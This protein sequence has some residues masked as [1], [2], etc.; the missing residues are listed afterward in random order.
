MYYTNQ[1]EKV[2]GSVQRVNN[3]EDI[4][5]A[6]HVLVEVDQKEDSTLKVNIKDKC[7]VYLCS[8]SERQKVPALPVKRQISFRG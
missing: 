7:P 3:K 2:K 1:Q 6:H 5:R 8:F 4:V